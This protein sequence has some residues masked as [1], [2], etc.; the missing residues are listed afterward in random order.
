MNTT[1]VSCQFMCKKVLFGNDGPL[2]EPNRPTVANMLKQ[3][4]YHTACI[5]KWH[6]GWN[7]ARD[8]EGRNRFLRPDF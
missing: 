7:W 4:G 2:I 6:L 3:Q 1:C 8:A 5:G